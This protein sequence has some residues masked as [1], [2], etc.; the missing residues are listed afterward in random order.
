MAIEPSRYPLPLFSCYQ[1]AI[2]ASWTNDHRR[3][4]RFGRAKNRDIDLHVFRF[5]T[6]H[7]RLNW[8]NGESFDNVHTGIGACQR[9]RSLGGQQIRGPAEESIHSKQVHH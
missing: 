7:R 2:A 8:P 3:A 5:M 4:I 9:G 6:A 1:S